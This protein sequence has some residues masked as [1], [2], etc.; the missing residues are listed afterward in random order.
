MEGVPFLNRV[1]KGD[2]TE[3]VTYEERTEEVRK[4]VTWLSGEK[5]I[6]PL[7]TPA[8]GVWEMAMKL[9][10]LEHSEQGEK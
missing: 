5:S 7:K 8:A 4:Q 2:T 1:I 6:L 3:N 10:G 9:E